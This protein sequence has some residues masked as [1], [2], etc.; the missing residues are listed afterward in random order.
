MVLF[1]FD[2]ANLLPAAGFGVSYTLFGKMFEFG[3][4]IKMLTN[5]VNGIAI[6]V[7]QCEADV[8]CQNAAFH[9]GMQ[10]VRQGMQ[11]YWQSDIVNLL[12]TTVLATLAANVI[13]TELNLRMIYRR[14]EQP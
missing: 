9:N 3:R 2:P 6:A 8:N 7:L 13:L 10:C 5:C 12:K 11:P 4:Q 14:P 1:R